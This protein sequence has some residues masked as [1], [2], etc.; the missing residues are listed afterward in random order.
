MKF[1]KIVTLVL[2]VSTISTSVITNV[3]S[4]N[5]NVLSTNSNFELLEAEKFKGV[6]LDK[7]RKVEVLS[8]AQ[9]EADRLEAAEL[10]IKGD[11]IIEESIA[12][13]VETVKE[14]AEILADD[15]LASKAGPVTEIPIEDIRY[16]MD[17]MVDTLKNDKIEL[18][19]DMKFKLEGYL[20]NHGPYVGSGKVVEYIENYTQADKR[21]SIEYNYNRTSAVDYAYKWVHAHNTTYYPNLGNED[22]TNYVS[23]VLAAGGHKQ[24]GNWWITKLNSQ[25]LEPKNG[26]E[27]RT[28]WASS[29]P[30]P[31]A[32]IYAP[33]F[34]TYWQAR[35]L[36]GEY[37]ATFV[38]DNPQVPYKAPYLLGDAVQVMRNITNNGVVV[39]YE[40]VHTMVITKYSPENQDYRVSYHSI[41]TKDKLLS[42]IAKGYGSGYRIRFYRMNDSRL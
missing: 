29:Y 40:P 2:I 12:N 26:I 19:E 17:V 14:L 15:E 37:D 4:A 39:G 38:R 16:I 41:N 9:L 42:H 6:D 36:T 27:Y 33:A 7:P 25:Y 32:W 23:Q 22:C 1:K 20:F 21:L 10:E 11:K 18:S 31:S 35:I 3:V 8:E 30:G 34:A 28:S 24:N 13:G 5:S